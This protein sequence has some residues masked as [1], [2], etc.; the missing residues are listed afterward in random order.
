[1]WFRFKD[2]ETD[3]KAMFEKYTDC[4]ELM[5]NQL[6]RTVFTIVQCVNVNSIVKLRI[7]FHKI[8]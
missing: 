2:I 1:V 8:G 7:P 6:L 3:Q 5:H 4:S